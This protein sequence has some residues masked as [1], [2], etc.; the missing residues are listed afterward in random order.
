MQVSNKYQGA[1]YRRLVL[2]HLIEEMQPVQLA[3]LAEHLEWPFRTVEQNVLN[4][5]SIGIKVA[6]VGSKRTG[7]YQLNDWGP[8]KREWVSDHYLEILKAIQLKE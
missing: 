1:F 3:V 6:R 7:G 2:A 8:I 5:H 4:L